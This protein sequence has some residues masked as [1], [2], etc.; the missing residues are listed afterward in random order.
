MCLIFLVLVGAF[1]GDGH[2]A[3]AQAFKES[4]ATAVLPF[5]FMRLIWASALGF[6]VFA[7]VPD[8]WTWIGGAVIFS[9]TVYIA[10][11]ETRL[12]KDGTTVRPAES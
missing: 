1:G 11:R 7:E 9:S 12:K 10:F 4:D 2:L 3:L 5:D 8:V 6:L